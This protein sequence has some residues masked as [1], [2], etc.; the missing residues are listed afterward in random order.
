MK[1]KKDSPQVYELYGLRVCSEL[2]LPAPVSED[3]LLPCDI[4]FRW[5]GTKPFPDC[6]PPG[7]VL[8][9]RVFDN[10]RGYTL[11]D[12]G[13]G[14]T[15]RFHQRGEF[16]ID[17]DLRSVCVHLFPDADPDVA[18]LLFTGNVLASILTLSG[19]CVLH[20]SA[21]KIG[22]EALAFV[23]GSGMGKSTLAALFCAQGSRF[24]TDDLLR[25]QPNGRGFGCFPGTGEIRLRRK[26]A[27]LA[28]NLTEATQGTTSDGRLALRFEGEQ[29]MPPLGAIVIP[30]P[31]RRCRALQIEQLSPAQALLTLMTYSR[32]Q[33]LQKQ[34]HLQQRLDACG[35][36]ASSVP[37]FEAEIPWGPP[38]APEIASALLREVGLKMPEEVLI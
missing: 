17:R 26:A 15:L 5:G 13:T 8:A 18:A 2:A 4:E 37:V 30:R 23:G 24:I 33:N 9:K 28:E 7:E 10:G 29:S 25:L 38:F 6:I 14:Y 11:T 32:I 19:E 34:K 36:I 1:E 27:A 20:A 16:R 31:S 21:V 3:P 22:D 35:K 12:T